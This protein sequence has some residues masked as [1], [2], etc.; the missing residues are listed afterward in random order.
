MPDTQ[1]IAILVATLIG[2]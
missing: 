2:F 1:G